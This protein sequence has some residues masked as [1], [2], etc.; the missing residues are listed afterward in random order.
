M[1]KEAQDQIK[2]KEKQ[3]K[4]KNIHTEIDIEW[5]EL[6]KEN[7]LGYVNQEYENE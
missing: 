1:M 4:V 7:M 5:E 6:S 2:G 3:L